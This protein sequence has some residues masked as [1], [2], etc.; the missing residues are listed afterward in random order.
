MLSTHD[1]N[2]AFALGSDVITMSQGH[3]TASG[4]ATEILTSAIL[5][6]VYGTPVA[7]ETLPSGRTVCH[8]GAG[9]T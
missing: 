7:V 5:S 1:P 3:L 9:R 4:R 6:E 8:H 2:Q